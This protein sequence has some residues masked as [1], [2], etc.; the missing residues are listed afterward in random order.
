RIAH[1]VAPETVSDA[2]REDPDIRG[3]LVVSP[4]YYGVAADVAAI[5]DVCHRHGVPLIV[6]EAWG[7]HFGFHP[8]LPPRAV[9]CGPDIVIAS[10]HKNGSGLAQSSVVTVRKGLVS[11]DDVKSRIDLLETASPQVP[12]LASIDGWRRHMALHGEEAL[13]HAL[14]LASRARE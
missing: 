14:G 9:S 4:T 12:I 5:A 11:P 6:D 1:P 8:D 7:D 3:V 2:L 10:V 13:G